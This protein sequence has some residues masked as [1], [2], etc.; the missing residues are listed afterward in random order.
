MFTSLS[1]L[2][3]ADVTAL[4]TLANNPQI[5]MWVRDIFPSPYTEQDARNFLAYLST[6]EPLTTFGIRYQN[7]LAGVCG[8]VL[9]QDIFRKSAEI[10]YWVGEPFWGRGIA[11]EAVR[12]LCQIGFEELG[13]V[14]IYAGVFP[15]NVASMRVL[16]KA[17]F[18]FESIA[19]KALIK[20]E[21]IYDDYIYRMTIEEWESSKKKA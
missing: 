2:T 20:R 4:A 19:K 17:G 13:L 8:L 16:E 11:T 9:Q 1:P 18:Q 12:L 6:Q 10:G 14:R 7:E 3:S 5:A 15:I 21:V